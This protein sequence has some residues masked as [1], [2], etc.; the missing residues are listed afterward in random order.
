VVALL[1][2]SGEAALAS[3]VSCWFAQ[4]TVELIGLIQHHLDGV[5]V[6]VELVSLTLLASAHSP[7]ASLDSGYLLGAV[8]VVMTLVL[9]LVVVITV[10]MPALAGCRLVL[11]CCRYQLCVLHPCG[12]VG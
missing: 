8:L 6:L 3:G 2:I 10:M 4:D 11:A 9:T 7:R 12:G 1:Q 5:L